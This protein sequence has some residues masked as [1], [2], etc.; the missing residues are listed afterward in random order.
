MSIIEDILYN[1]ARNFTY[2]ALDKGMQAL[3]KGGQAV[4]RFMLSV[5]IISSLS[6]GKYPSAKIDKITSDGYNE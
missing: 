4:N 2:K 6:Q 3:K 5:K 1:T